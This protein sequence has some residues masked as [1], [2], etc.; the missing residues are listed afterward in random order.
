MVM[1]GTRKVVWWLCGGLLVFL[2]LVGYWWFVL[3]V[4]FTADADELR[5]L[6]DLTLEPADNSPLNAKDW[7][8]W[9]G[10]RRDG[11][12]TAPDL[13]VSWPE[14]GP[15]ERWRVKGGDGYSSF[16]LTR[17]TAYSM[18][19]LA[20]ND[21]AVMA[22][23]LD[24][25][26]VRWRHVY[27]R[28]RSFDYR[29]PRATPTLAG[30]LLY[31]VSAAGQLMCLKADTGEPHWQVDL[32]REVQGQPPPWG[33]AFSPLVEDGLVYTMPGGQNEQ[34]LAA[35]DA[36]TGKLAWASQNDPA[37]YS[38]PILL[39]VAGVRQVVFFT[40][41]RLLGVTPKKGEL[42]WEYPWPTSNEITVTTPMA[43]RGRQGKREEGYLFISSGYD[44][45]CALVRVA[46]QDGRFTARRVYESSELCCQFGTPVLHRDHLYALDQKRDLTCLDVR[47]GA[48]RWRKRGFERGTLIRVDDRLVVLGENGR[49]ALVE[50]DPKGYRQ[51]ASARVLKRPCWTLPVLA[52]GMLLVRDQNDVVC[53]DV[54]KR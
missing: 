24:S 13:L 6:R 9:C 20:G 48:V 8:Q 40:G 10:Q 22:W 39:T 30:G 2:G 34:C 44:K 42:L 4:R 50:C 27:D 52:D 21:E 23:R 53:L 41:R 18:V 17:D 36:Q 12:T 16:A 3:R 7:P 31:T 54:R 1:S 33:F 11:V 45:G 28:G 32:V 15:T 47:T 49:L 14:A 37:G 5:L 26:K 43:I 51:T 29:G 38:S 35:F 25:G 46:E 19:A